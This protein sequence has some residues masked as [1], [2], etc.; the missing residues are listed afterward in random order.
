MRSNI[1]E[2]PAARPYVVSYSMTCHHEPAPAGAGSA[3]RSERQNSGCPIQAKLEWGVKLGDGRVK[4]CHPERGRATRARARVEGPTVRWDRADCGCPILS[5][6][7]GDRV[8]A[9]TT[10]PSRPAN[11]PRCCHP[12]RSEV[13][14]ATERSRRTPFQELLSLV[15]H[16]ERSESPRRRSAAEGPAFRLGY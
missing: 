10:N 5:P 1:V 8:G 12:E 6:A 11:S 4:R 9:L 2:G 14:Q 7:F 16:P 3:V 13:A 15:C